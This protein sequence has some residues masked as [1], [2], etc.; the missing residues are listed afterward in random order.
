MT[1]KFIKYPISLFLLSS[2]LWGCQSDYTKMVKSELAKG[3]RQDS[4]LFGIEFGQTRQDFFGKCFDL[5][6]QHLVTEG[7]GHGA[8]Y[9][10][11]DSLVHPKPIN[12]R[13]LFYPTFDSQEK[14][15]EMNLEFSYA[16]WSPVV[17]ELQA[18][19]LKVR[20][21]EL[22]RKWYGGNNFVV[23]NLK[24][25]E[26]PVKLDGNRRITVKIKDIRTVDV[27]VQDLLHP[28]FKHPS[29]SV[30]NFKKTLEK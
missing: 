1:L 4:I 18:D 12:M 27:K 14:I 15:M 16:T 30:E 7:A 11:S 29:I 8:Q 13:L 19:S 22:L 21:M 17:K 9:D 10:F 28:R 23:A 3:V 25:G 2:I 24:D 20:V 6:K 26:V 5:N